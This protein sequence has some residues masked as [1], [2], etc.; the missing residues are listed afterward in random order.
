MAGFAK[1]A[2]FDLGSSPGK[3]AKPSKRLPAELWET[4]RP[5]ITRLYQ[6][7]N[8]SLK[9]VMEIMQRKHHFVATVKMY[10]SRI[11]KWG[12][13]KKL[14]GDEVLAIM[15]LKQDRDVLKKPTE[16]RIRG[17]LVDL[18]NIGRYL[19]RNP[20][21]MAKF[22]AGQIPSAQ[23]ALEVTCR[24]P[25]PPPSPSRVLAPTTEMQSTEQV[26]CLFRD[27]IDGS[28]SSGAW[29]CEFDVDCSNG[30]FDQG[31]RSNDLFE[32][33]I[34]SFAL[35]NRCMMTGD[36]I[37]LNDILG[38]AF[39][40]LKEIVAAESPSFVARTVC[41]LW[42]LDRH[43][44]HDLLRLVLD[45]LTGLVPIVLGPHHS[46]AQIWRRLGSSNFSDYYELSM[47]LY[48]LLIP[49]I[50]ERAGSASYLTHLLYSDYLDC[51]FAR[52]DAEDCEAMLRSHLARAEASGQTQ[53]WLDDMALSHAGLLAACKENQGR[54]DEAVEV[55]TMHMNAYNMTEEQE[56]AV[57]LE[58]G[59]K[60]YRMSNIPAAI[61]S[62]KSAARIAL[63]S[64]ADERI[65]MT[66]LA[67]LENLLQQTNKMTEADRV[68]QYRLQR[69]SAFAEQSVSISKGLCDMD[70]DDNSDGTG[71]T[72]NLP[73]WLWDC[74]YREESSPG[75]SEMPHF[76]WAE[77]ASTASYTWAP[78]SVLETEWTN[79]SQPVSPIITLSTE[80]SPFLKDMIADPRVE[81]LYRDDGG[82]SVD[83]VGVPDMV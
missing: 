57:N 82:F 21:V 65:S 27:Y 76:D 3:S 52:K 47:R 33:V 2:P 74:D 34:A 23:T 64:D 1:K 50:E 9:E 68:H 75:W 8:K 10:K 51:M 77:K 11:W 83:V 45:Y 61:A 59:V 48:A 22:K 5:I 46:L 43:H 28:F 7:E 60:Y 58:I 6:E 63:T 66:A 79:T 67:N 13:D 49:D 37:D 55:L 4:K 16:F 71:D 80:H 20:S 36:Q 26:L 29:L 39:E 17:Q 44:K 54:L 62:F 30:R 42:Y 70:G 15:L 18:E 35:V 72:E 24:T 40:S 73:D 12:L 81:Y 31:D 32:R 56:A 38:P 41:L 25:S 14:K 53:P 69:L 78:G 19:K